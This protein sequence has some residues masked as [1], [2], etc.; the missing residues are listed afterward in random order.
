M[1]RHLIW[2]PVVGVLLLS[3]CIGI[4]SDIRIREDG[5][6]SLSLSYTV[7]QFIKNLDAGRSEKRLPLPV[8]EEEFRRVA[9]SIEGLRL[10][11]LEQTEDQENVHIR[12]ELEFDS[13]AALNGLGRQGDLGISLETEG[14]TGTFSQL[15]YAG[16]EE[17]ISP[18]SLEMI[19][20]FFEGYDLVYSIT[21][22]AQVRRHTLGEL[23]SEGRTVTYT[24][25]VPEILQSTEPLVLEVAW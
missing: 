3:S 6:G 9:E 8:N 7:S 13:I 19:Q 17:E 22:P 24:T 20:T 25:T 10:T 18:E 11:D 12:A 16:Q 2:V 1:T 14:A 23:D 15:I 21:A 4:R 5:S